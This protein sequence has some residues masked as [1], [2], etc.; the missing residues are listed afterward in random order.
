MGYTPNINSIHI[1]PQTNMSAITWYVS[2][3]T[4]INFKI[5]LSAPAMG[6]YT[7]GWSV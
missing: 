5:K 7:F 3:V 4:T 2:S 1:T 6:N